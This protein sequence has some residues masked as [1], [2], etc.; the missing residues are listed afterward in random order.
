METAYRSTSILFSFNMADIRNS[1]LLH[2]DADFRHV[3]DASLVIIKTEWNAEIVDSLYAG[4]LKSLTEAGVK[5]VETLIVPGAFEIPFGI[6]THW[7][8][9]KYK[10]DRPDGYIALGCVIRGDTPHFEYVCRGVTDGVLQ[11]NMSL[12]VPVIFGVLTVDNMQQALA[13]TKGPHGNKGEE[14]AVTALKMVVLSRK[15]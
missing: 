13:R 3:A 5:K 15:E 12:P 14:S 1:K 8:R 10:S 7:E 11:L 6:K 9:H 4:C 2:P